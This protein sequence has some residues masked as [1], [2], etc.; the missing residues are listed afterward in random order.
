MNKRGLEALFIGPALVHLIVFALFPI[1][2]VFVLSFYQWNLLADN[3]YFIGFDNYILLIQNDKFWQAMLNT[4]KFVALSVPASIAVALAVALFVSQ[5]IKASVVFRTVF[6]LP[7]VCSGVALAMM[8]IYIYL[9]KSGMVNATAALF[10]LPSSTD[11]LNDVNWAMPAIAF[12]SVW[13]GLGPRMVL[14]VA[15]LLNIPVAL[16]EAAQLD[17]ASGWKQFWSITL[18][19]LSP[20]TLFV[21]VTATIGAFQLFTPIYM[22]TKGGPLGTTDVVG[23][24]V[25]N[26]AWRRFQIGSASAQSVVIFA[27]IA[28]VAWVQYKWLRPNTDLRGMA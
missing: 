21:L 13:T 16:Y 14:Y 4:L 28:L 8:W 6:Y 25:Y 5:K 23:Y 22:M 24:H 17:G 26:E 27:L 3:R 9:P 12:M 10:G 20:T 18:P 11:F 1:G 19:L 15:G 7:S 2:Y